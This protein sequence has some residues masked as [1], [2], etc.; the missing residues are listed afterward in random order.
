MARAVVARFAG[1]C[2]A[3]QRPIEKGDRIVPCA[4]VYDRWDHESCG[5]AAVR[6]Y[7]QQPRWTGL[8]RAGDEWDGRIVQSF[9]RGFGDALKAWRR[10]G[11]EVARVMRTTT[12]E[13][14]YERREDGEGLWRQ[15]S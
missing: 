2:E 6:G 5:A 9:A 11:V 10:E 15:K 7:E 14:H 1:R 13:E 12:F 3:C 4:G 8:V